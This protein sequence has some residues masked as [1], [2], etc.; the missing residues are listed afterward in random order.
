MAE[1]NTTP[2]DVEP[3][4][5]STTE[6]VLTSTTEPMAQA[7]ATE[8]N[9]EIAALAAQVQALTTPEVTVQTGSHPAPTLP[10]H[11]GRVVDFG[12]K[13]EVACI[14]PWAPLDGETLF[15]GDRALVTA[16]VADS[17]PTLARV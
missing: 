13:V 4:L 11:T 14:T 8:R 15:R 17:N 16:K 5:T 7:P 6:P 2:Q 12:G 3:T 1:K 10:R 9:D